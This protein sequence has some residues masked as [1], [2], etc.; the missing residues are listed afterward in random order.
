M[1]D[2]AIVRQ[3]SVSREDGGW[4][5]GGPSLFISGDTIGS[6]SRRE[7]HSFRT[8]GPPQPSKRD[9]SYISHGCH[10]DCGKWLWR[11][12]FRS[13][14]VTPLG[15]AM[16]VFCAAIARERLAGDQKWFLFLHFC[17]VFNKAL[18]CAI[19]ELYCYCTD[20]QMFKLFVLFPFFSRIKC[21]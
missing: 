19:A 3:G 7:S 17:F 4:V 2:Y 13:S 9:L 18:C 16:V 8:V 12:G 11:E 14:A 21:G 5:G 15:I 20:T 1:R 10:G 6:A